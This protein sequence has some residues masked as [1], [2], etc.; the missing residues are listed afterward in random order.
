MTE[1]G[2]KGRKLQGGQ[3]YPIVVR[4]CGSACVWK[5]KEISHP[6]PQPCT[7]N[8]EHREV[9]A[10]EATTLPCP[11]SSRLPYP[12]EPLSLGQ[13]RNSTPSTWD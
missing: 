11:A 1:R 3:G 13:H 5:V 6:T 4:V 2:R 10:V 12:G 9:G 7:F 8:R